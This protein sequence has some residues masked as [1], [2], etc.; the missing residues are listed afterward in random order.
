[1]L[2]EATHNDP[3]NNPIDSTVIDDIR[4]ILIAIKHH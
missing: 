4:S 3:L 2:N 1:M